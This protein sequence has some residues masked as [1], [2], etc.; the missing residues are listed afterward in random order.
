MSAVN[1][2]LREQLDQALRA[3]AEAL[4]LAA[5]L[6]ASPANGRVCAEAIQR[7][8]ALRARRVG[9]QRQVRESRSGGAPPCRA[10]GS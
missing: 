1:P 5:R 8:E 3:E 10:T 2:S 6:A 7:A 9:V 4:Q